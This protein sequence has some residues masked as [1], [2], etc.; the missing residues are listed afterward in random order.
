M[1]PRGDGAPAPGAFLVPASKYR[2]PTATGFIVRSRDA[3]GHQVWK[4]V[5]TLGEA[6]AERARAE[7]AERQ[8]RR[9]PT[10]P[11][12][13]TVAD[14]F[15]EFLRIHGVTLKRRTCELYQDQFRRYIEPAFGRTRVRSLQRGHIKR[16]LADLLRGGL[17]RDTCGSPTLPC[18]S[19]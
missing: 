12:T 19:C 1:A 11:A 5:A 2:G 7:L 14:Y 17:D 10:V 16:W 9:Q 4:T 13:I 3:T 8:P 15:P 18:M 6:K